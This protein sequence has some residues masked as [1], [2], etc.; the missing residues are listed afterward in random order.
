M[1]SKLE[2]DIDLVVPDKTKTLR[3]GALV[4]WNPISS[5]YYPSM[6]EQ[7]CKSEKID[8]D[9]PFNKLTKRQR[10]KI[11]YGNGDKLFHFH[12]ENDFGGVRDVDVPFEGVVNNVSRRYKETNSDFTR[13]QM[14]KYMA[15]LPCPACHGY[16]LN[17]QALSVKIDGENIGEISALPI[18]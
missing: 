11:L 15:E 5:Q 8:M 3:E 18:S 7:F 16:R 14:R 1:G 2:V 17:E 9:K 4:P 13:E 10:E 12:Y 6:L